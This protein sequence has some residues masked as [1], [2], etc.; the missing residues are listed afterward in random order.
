MVSRRSLTRGSSS[1]FWLLFQN[2]HQR[3]G[4]NEFVDISEHLLFFGEKDQVFSFR[5]TN[6]FGTAHLRKQRPF[7]L[8]QR[9]AGPNS[10]RITPELLVGLP[11][12]VAAAALAW[13]AGACEVRQRG[14]VWHS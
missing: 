9:H 7:L 2:C 1:C 14:A 6:D 13:L 5:Q 3:L 8:L 11:A 10:A 4:G 12:E